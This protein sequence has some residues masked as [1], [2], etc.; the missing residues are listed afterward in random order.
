[1]DAN[2]VSA[3]RVVF[4]NGTQVDVLS[5]DDI[6]ILGLDPIVP[7]PAG[8]W[9]RI[10]MLTACG[11]VRRG[12]N[13]YAAMPIHLAM[14][15]SDLAALVVQLESVVAGLP[16]DQ[17]AGYEVKRTETI[18]L[19]ESEDER[20]RMAAAAFRGDVDPRTGVQDNAF[21][22]AVC[23]YPGHPHVSHICEWHGAPVSY[24][25]EALSAIPKAGFLTA[26]KSAFGKE[27]GGGHRCDED[28][29]DE[30]GPKHDAPFSEVRQSEASDR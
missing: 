12:N 24:E 5:E 2:H 1:M 29:E 9:P 27:T 15:V 14:R 17:L 19:I 7:T 10:S 3:D 21:T 6:R 23:K 28:C 16:D 25:N 30:A 4:T 20:A 8:Q 22:T 11:V 13:T 18:E 26:I